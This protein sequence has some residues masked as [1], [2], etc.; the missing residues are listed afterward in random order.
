MDNKIGNFTIGKHFDALKIDLEC[1]DSP[2]DIYNELSLN[3]KLQK[4]LYLG[5][6][7]N[8]TQV[9]VNGKLVKNKI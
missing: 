4:F 1:N 3:E 7:R 8:I 6:D 9:Y 2:I 5:D